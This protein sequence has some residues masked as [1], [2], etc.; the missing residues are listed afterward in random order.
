MPTPSIAIDD[1]AYY[2]ATNAFSGRPRFTPR[3]PDLSGSSFNPGACW[4]IVSFACLTLKATQRIPT[5]VGLRSVAVGGVV[6]EIDTAHGTQSSAVGLAQRLE[7]QAQHHVV[8]K[9][10]LEVDQIALQPAGLVLGRRHCPGTRT[11]PEDRPR[12]C[13]RSPSS[14]GR[15]A[16]G[17]SRRRFRR[18]ALPRSPIRVEDR[19]RP[20][21]RVALRSRRFPGPRELRRMSEPPPSRPRDAP[22]R[23][24]RG[25][26]PNGG[27]ASDAANPSQSFQAER[28]VPRRDRRPSLPVRHR[29]TSQTA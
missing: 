8:S 6:V 7:R 4:Y 14:T 9:E 19:A 27:P 28:S 26:I 18:P 29:G 22:A 16:R 12:H 13:R 17:P 25:P 15:T 2:C 20:E 5:G 23:G 3:C 10:W 11:A 24:C 21:I 1:A